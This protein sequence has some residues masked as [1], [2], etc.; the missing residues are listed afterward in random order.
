MKKTLLFLLSATLL[1]GQNVNVQKAADGTNAI[2]G[3]LVVGSGK[4][5]L[6]SGTGEIRA[7][8]V[9]P[10]FTVP[11]AQVN[12]TGSSLADL[13][14]RSAAALTSG[15]LD[16][17]RLPAFSGDASSSA[18]SSVL[19]LATV[20]SNLGTF[21]GLTV[22]GKGLVTAATQFTLTTTA[23]LQGG[24]A[25]GN[26]TFS[27]P[28]ST[29][30]VDGYLTAAD[31]T[32]FSA[33][34]PAGNYI[35]ALTGDVT[36]SGPGS[37]VATYAG[38]LPANK[39]GAGSI[40]GILKANGSGL[41]SAAASGIDYAPPTSGASLLY[42]NGSGGFSN[43]SVGASMSFSGGAVNTVQSITT[44]ATPTFSA[45]T[46]SSG[47]I[48]GISTNSTPDT[49]YGMGTIIFIG[50]SLA[51]GEAQELATISGY[52]VI[53]M[54]IGGQNSSLIKARFD[55][56][57]SAQLQCNIIIWAGTNDAPS[58]TNTLSNIAAM[59]ARIP[60]NRYVV[61]GVM[62]N[63]NTT[64]NRGPSGAN[65]LAKVSI[66][67]QL[68]TTYGSHFYN[69]DSYLVTQYNPAWPGDV[70]AYGWSIP[71]PS[72][73]I[74]PHPN[75][76]GVKLIQ[77]QVW[78]VAAA[79]F[80]S[81][82]QDQF[83]T[84]N[85]VQAMIKSRGNSFSAL[86]VG[87]SGW[88]NEGNVPT[89]P[90]LANQLYAY[91]NSYFEG[92]IGVNKVTPTAAIDIGGL[93]P[94]PDSYNPQPPS[95]GSVLQLTTS[96]EVIFPVIQGSG[97][98]GGSAKVFLDQ[99]QTAGGVILFNQSVNV[100]DGNGLRKVNSSYNGI[101]S[102]PRG[103]YS[104]TIPGDTASAYYSGNLGVNVSPA[105]NATQA[106]AHVVGQAAASNSSGNTTYYGGGAQH[107]AGTLTF[108]NSY[109]A[110][111]AYTVNVQNTTTSTARFFGGQPG[112]YIVGGSGSTSANSFGGG[113][114]GVVGIG[115]A[116]ASLSGSN[117]QGG[118]GGYFSPG[119]TANGGPV[120]PAI[121]ANGYIGLAETNNPNALANLAASLELFANSS[122]QLSWMQ[123]SGF[124]ISLDGTAA[125]ASRVFTLPN[126]TGT[127]VLANNTQTLSNKTLTGTATNDNAPA[128]AVGEYISSA[129][130]SGS[131]VSL[132]AATPAN[133]TS[134]SLT[135]G[136]W[137]VSGAVNYVI[138]AP[139][140]GCTGKA[141]IS[142]TSA[143]Q[144]T[145]GSEAYG[146][147][148]LGLNYSV[149]LTRKRF[150]LSSTTTVYL[151]GEA[152]TVAAGPAGVKA[153]GTITARRVR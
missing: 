51:L 111:S 133:V 150:S 76:A 115:G 42:G 108:G 28:A 153:Y 151:V 32:A 120:A 65:Y 82:P 98:T 146:Q 100:F 140:G 66:N 52:K 68:A 10:L 1:F 112:A 27:I 33:K 105:V 60:H 122:H 72:L 59:V 91:G 57:T 23:P 25:L 85:E 11:W 34:Q 58:Y 37:S 64:A 114:A 119:A 62:T 2:T 49:M 80:A 35:T 13:Q 130:A 63:D 143:T 15:I 99:T 149:P 24:G 22:N 31:H 121:Y 104:G 12:K 107:N 47:L 128:G 94:I 3:N 113:G 50:D 92:Q 9:S 36:A 69:A 40:S 46:T 118:A 84:R 14:T 95:N 77:N 148:T 29:N 136:D 71:P 30:S 93:S 127:F 38:V 110:G 102:L 90:N 125:T 17:L 116:G 144:A 6:P 43:A 139:N 106:A 39:G 135:A 78:G 70:Q 21:N 4:S 19:T 87:D 96:G 129:V 61:M 142:S 147:S 152:P 56:L 41:V 55:A 45:L 81:D 124:S 48:N 79:L 7:T 126:A 54:G 141:S 44:S 75:P 137:D 88:G 132:T 53:N 73:D 103:S 117:A 101:P 134:I 109:G 5:L 26:L 67:N 74:Y 16:P 138:D 97:G 145:D 83:V 20:N 18:G 89:Q 123:P 86:T 131:A 8:S